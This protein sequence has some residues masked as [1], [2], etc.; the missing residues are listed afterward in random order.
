M[1]ATDSSGTRPARIL[2]VDDE[3]NNR[4]LL[5]VMLAPDGYDVVMAAA[6]EEALAMI[7]LH[8]PDLIVLDVMMPGMDGYQVAAR[9][10][11]EDATRHIPIIM[12]TALNDRNSM[13]HG[14][15]AGAEQFLTK[16][17]VRAE[18]S[19]R[20]RNLLRL[21]EFPEPFRQPGE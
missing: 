2:V 13:M 14:L 21:T 1:S 9:I 18:L 4:L 11:S 15:N 5:K 10:K 12:L 6:G 19:L 16:P 7:A 20:V 3:P 17:V 8:P